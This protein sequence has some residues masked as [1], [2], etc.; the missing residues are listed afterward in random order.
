ME[1]NLCKGGRLMPRKR[2]ISPEFWTDDNILELDY[3]CRLL[4]IGLWNFCD[5][6]GIH[7]NNEKVL[8]AEIFPVDTISVEEIRVYLDNLIELGLL[9]VS[10][11]NKLL[12]VKNWTNYQKIQHKTPSKY[13]EMDIVFNEKHNTG[14]IPV[15]HNINNINKDNINKN[16]VASTK[17]KQHSDMKPKPYKER[18]NDWYKD[19]IS[20]KDKMKQFNDT[21]PDV[22]I[23]QKLLE[24]K[25][26]LLHN[27]RK[28]Y[29]KTFFNW[30]SNHT[31]RSNK[32][33]YKN[34]LD[35][36][37]AKRNKNQAVI[38]KKNR[39]QMKQLEKDAASTEDIQSIVGDIRK[40]L[41]NKYKWS[42]DTNEQ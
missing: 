28:N 15:H 4:F 5:D 24:C 1:S 20:N 26:W 17:K 36:E 10:E 21:F 29:D 14:I 31:G 13:E 42:N 9:L 23:K 18:V 16:K 8:K 25:S 6:I 27:V 40:Q 30:C 39:Q 41:N 2:V 32:P 12:K 22:D 35:E 38:D 34:A 11:D 33:L 7:K 19:F 3:T 37:I